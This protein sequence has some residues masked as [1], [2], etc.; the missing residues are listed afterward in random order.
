MLCDGGAA[1]RAHGIS[2]ARPLRLADELDVREA[3]L[4][5]RPSHP[6][7]FTALSGRPGQPRTARCT[8]RTPPRALLRENM[9]RTKAMLGC[10]ITDPGPGRSRT[11]SLSGVT[12]TTSSAPWDG[13]SPFEARP[14]GAS[15][16]GRAPLAR[17]DCPHPQRRSRS[18]AAVNLSASTSPVGHRAFSSSAVAK[19]VSQRRKRIRRN[20]WST[21][22]AGQGLRLLLLL[23]VLRRHAPAGP[24]E[25]T[26]FV[27][28][29]TATGDP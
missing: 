2:R 18:L 11:A 7:P 13:H 24:C 4:R 14:C 20:G 23:L 1:A 12:R 25:T 3:A 28:R 6:R 16:C 8:K 21:S 9:A 26:G 19:L 10:L 29:A 15:W 27:P 5:R 17:F 22:N